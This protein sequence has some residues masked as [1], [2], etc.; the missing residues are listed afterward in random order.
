MNKKIDKRYILI[1]ILGFIL[2][3]VGSSYALWIEDLYQDDENVMATS[4][5]NVTLE[6]ADSIGLKNA[7]PLYDKDGKKLTPYTFTIK[8]NCE[9]YASYQ[10]NFETLTA[11]TLTNNSFIKLMLNN[12][13]PKLL[14]DYQSTTTTLDTSSN[15]YVLATGALDVN[16]SKTYELRLWIDEKVTTSDNV[17]NTK[18]SGQVTVTASYIEYLPGSYEECVNKYGADSVQCTIIAEAKEDASLCPT[19]NDDGTVNITSAKYTDALVCSAP[20]DYGTSYYYRGVPENNWVK[21]G[22]YYWRILRVNGDKSIRM[23]LI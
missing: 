18:F 8:N 9:A 4:C 16:E 3:L 2:V 21:F 13:S 11:N 12:E 5:F 19:V 20:D 22:G 17:Q 23:I 15:A 7:Y 6:Q 10:V 14:S 1:I